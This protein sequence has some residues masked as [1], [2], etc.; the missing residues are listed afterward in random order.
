MTDQQPKI[1]A[2]YCRLSKDDERMGESLSIE[3]QKTILSQY[4]R[5]NNHYPV[6]FYIDDGYTGL[7]FDRPEFQ[8]MIDD[9][10]LGK[11]GTVITKDL[12]RLGRDHIMTGQYAEIYFP[13]H[14][15]RY[16]AINDGFDS[17]NQQSTV[18]ASL[19]TAINEFYSRDASVKIKASFRARAKEG[20]HHSTV[21]PYGY[22][23]DPN[24]KNN[25]IPDPETAKYIVKIYD[26]VLQG[27][28]NH[29]IRDYLRET[30]V[31][32]PSWIHHSR[33][34]LNKEQMFPTEESKYIWRPDS[35]RNIIRNPVYCG[36]L[37]YGKSETIFKTK[38]HPQ[39]DESKWIVVR[40]THEA[41]VSR[42]IWER[43]N[44]LIAI[45]RQ[46]YKEAYAKKYHPNLF[47]GILKCADCDKAMTRRRY[48]S[49]NNRQI[50]VCTTY[51]AY[52]SYRC[53]QHK[54]FE[55]DIKEVVLN[56]IRA[57]CREAKLD[58]Q[59]LIERIVQMTDTGPK[60]E[61]SQETYN[62][63]KKRMNELNQLHD[64]LYE[65]H[66][67]GILSDSNYK[68]MIVKYQ[69]EQEDL[70]QKM[71]A[72]E[73]ANTEVANRRT[74]AEEV[75]DL[76]IVYGEFTEL[77]KGLLNALVDKITVS[78]P[79]IIDGRFKQDITIYYRNIGA[80]DVVHNDATRFYKSEECMY[81]SQKRASREKEKRVAAVLE[82]AAR[83]KGI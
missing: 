59:A 60:T 72:Y 81:A 43:A 23:K 54:L 5:E 32:C 30:R 3:T 20:K 64:K 26:L 8:R 49:K 34:W 29:R 66:L 62:S 19:K 18:Y 76:F 56:D 31:P 75:A 4:A 61:Y 52:G 36:D 48:G 63:W 9:I 14:K 80:L 6:E 39:T 37:V 67:F 40:D 25:L 21:P 24:N 35:L 50:Y 70:R 78:E 27:W 42:D 69:K 47:N 12:S 77:T 83:D 10:A 53:T 79:Y 11:I 71:D 15:V 46:D 45:K 55:D 44:R 51:A 74:K 28:G 16:I 58:R 65:D 7:N 68:R 33:G 17:E 1:T 13:T 41:I 22:L 82:E 38:R 2:L 73:N 57:L